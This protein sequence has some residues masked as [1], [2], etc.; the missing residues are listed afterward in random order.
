VRI[1]VVEFAGR[2]GLAQYAFQLCRALA[3]AGADVTLITSAHYEMDA[4]PHR[5]AVE[6]RLRLW[7][8]K[9]AMGDA[10]R[11]LRRLLRRAG[12]GLRHSFEWARLVAHLART[13]PDVVQLGD[14][15]FASDLVWLLALR[16][17]GLRLADVCHNVFPFAGG[18]GGG[19][20]RRSGAWRALFAAVYRCFDVVFVHF[21]SNR[22]AL[23]DAYRLRP[24]RVAAIPHG[25]EAVFE[26]LRDGARTPDLIRAQ[27][28]L[29]P[30]EPVVL[31]LGTLTA[32]K[33][34]DGLLQAFPRVRAAVPS[35][36]LV[37]AGHPAPDFDA[38]AVGERVR[39]LGLDGAVH[40]VARY[41]EAPDVA[42]WL[43]MASV[44]VFPYRAV[45]QSGA[46]V[47]AQTFGL[48]VVATRVG[49]MEEEVEDGRTGLLVPPGNE[50]AQADAL[51]ALLSDPRRAREMGE[52]GRD[53]ARTAFSWDLVAGLVRARYEA[54]VT[55]ARARAGA[56]ERARP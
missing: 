10:P 56:A 16:L 2:G 4:L 26:E 43:E 29:A 50:V 39:A 12:R 34:V 32:Y 46:V 9:P 44:A 21:E 41:V 5:F 54:L 27:L 40:I 11:G 22:R 3:A 33:G 55:P 7:D 48:P 35:A 47:L 8:P 49:A 20:P 14:V 38:E 36:R 18:P 6:K 19:L 42:A 23:L 51:T 15:R 45:F 1:A 13:R 53:R 37:V 52:L 25:N 31:L 24:E 17:L 28:G 30:D